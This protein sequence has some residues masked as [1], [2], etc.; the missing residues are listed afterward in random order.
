MSEFLGLNHDVTYCTEVAE[1]VSFGA[2]REREQ[3]II[4]TFAFL[5]GTKD[6][7]IRKGDRALKMYISK[8]SI[9]V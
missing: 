1:K 7:F 5:K 3:Q 9:S 4:S 6:G 8:Y 2:M